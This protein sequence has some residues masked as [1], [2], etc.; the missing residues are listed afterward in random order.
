MEWSNYSQSGVILAPN[1]Y[2]SHTPNVQRP[3]PTN[4]LKREQHL[5]LFFSKLFHSERVMSDFRP[6]VVVTNGPIFMY[7]T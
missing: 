3:K 7:V 6:S 5:V 1:P 4:F 2:F